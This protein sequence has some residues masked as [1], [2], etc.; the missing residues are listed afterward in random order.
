MT[1]LFSV[2]HIASFSAESP[3][4]ASSA[5]SADGPATL[6]TADE[7]VRRFNMLERLQRIVKTRVSLKIGRNYLMVV[8]PMTHLTMEQFELQLIY[9]P[10]VITTG[11]RFYNNVA[12][13]TVVGNSKQKT[14]SE[15]HLFQCIDYPVSKLSYVIT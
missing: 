2:D 1:E 5:A 4:S 9:R 10:A 15:V 8:D 7:V 14:P 12:M 3:S 11:S 6:I 13:V